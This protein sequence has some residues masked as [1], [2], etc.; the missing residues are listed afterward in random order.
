MVCAWFNSTHAD[1]IINNRPNIFNRDTTNKNKMKQKK[2]SIKSIVND[3]NRC[4]VLLE[5]CKVT[6]RNARIRN[7]IDKLYSI[8][9][10]RTSELNLVMLPV[11]NQMQHQ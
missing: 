3:L 4:T 10:I 5:G 8:L 6:A 11:R 1:N 9:A 2:Q 7:R